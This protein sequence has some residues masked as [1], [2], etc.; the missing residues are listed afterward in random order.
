MELCEGNSIEPFNQLTSAWKPLED[1]EVHNNCQ[2]PTPN[3]STYQQCSGDPTSIVLAKGDQPACEAVRS[4][5]FP[6][7]EL[8]SIEAD[9]AIDD[10]DETWV[11]PLWI[12]PTP[13]N[14]CDNRGSAP[15]CNQGASGEID[16]VETCMNGGKNTV[17]TSL[18]ENTCAPNQHGDSICFQQ[19]Y[20]ATGMQL[21]YTLTV[22]QTLGSSGKAT[23]GVCDQTSKGTCEEYVSSTTYSDWYNTVGCVQG[24][25]K[26]Q[27]RS[28]IWA[29]VPGQYGPGGCPS[30]S[31]AQSCTVSA[32][33]IKVKLSN[34]PPDGCGA[35]FER[36]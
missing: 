28:D 23:M 10:C 19:Q 21:H 8:V 6:L 33:N 11:A 32:R 26:F 30:K 29:A 36:A 7:K 9:I 22:D 25:C 13:P 5:D 18:G 17:A 14:W 20:P 31:T 4:C 2:V 24:E 34:D 16:F 27:L 15:I 35:M 3:P 12:T 1:G